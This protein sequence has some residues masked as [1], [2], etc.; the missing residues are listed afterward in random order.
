VATLGLDVPSWE[1]LPLLHAEDGVDYAPLERNAFTV[2]EF[3]CGYCSFLAI[4]LNEKYKWP[5]F[6]EVA[7]DNYGEMILHV[8]VRDPFGRAVDIRGTH[9]GPIPECWTSQPGNRIRSYSET[10]PAGLDPTYDE[11][12]EWARNLVRKNF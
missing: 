6:A 3:T 1:L 4:A 5:M 10:M 9:P 11:T 7:D 8:F 12:L 2:E